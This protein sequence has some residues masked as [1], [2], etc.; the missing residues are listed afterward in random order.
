M[1]TEREYTLIKTTDP[2]SRYFL[3]K[4]GPSAVVARIDL[5]GMPDIINVLS[6]RAETV[7]IMDKLRQE[8]GDHPD[9][10][11]HIFY[12]KVRKK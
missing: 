3:I 7:L 6:G 9:K 1:L 2:G 12:D 10:W 11:L 8:Y 4:Q 5:S